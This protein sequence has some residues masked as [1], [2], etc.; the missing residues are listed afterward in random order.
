MTSYFG[1]MALRVYF[2]INILIGVSLVL[3]IFCILQPGLSRKLSSIQLFNMSAI[4]LF[5]SL[6]VPIIFSFVPNN[7]LPVIR[8]SPTNSTEISL[9]SIGLKHKNSRF[10]SV[11]NKEI[12]VENNKHSWLNQEFIRSLESNKAGWFILILLLLSIL[13]LF[14]YKI[15]QLMALKR[16]ILRG[17]QIRSLGRTRIFVSD[18]ISIPFSTL[19][20]K[21]AYVVLPTHLFN[22]GE[23]FKIACKHE[24]QHHRQHDTLFVLLLEAL[25][26]VFYVNPLV[27][28]WKRRIAELQ[29]LSCDEVLIGRKKISSHGYASC[30]VRVAEAAF[31]C[32]HM[33]VGTACMGAGSKNPVYFKSFLRRRIEMLKGYEGARRQSRVSLVLGSISVFLVVT[34]AYGAQQTLRAQGSFVNAGVA[35]FD[36]MVQGI[37]EHYLKQEID[38]VGADA[39]Y[40]IVSDPQTGRVLAVANI[41]K[42]TDFTHKEK[43]W[44]LSLLA[45]PASLMKGIVAAAAVDE[46]LTKLN[47]IHHCENG[48]YFYNGRTY[49]DWKPFSQ[50]TTEDT[51]AQ[52]SNI[53]GIKLAEKLGAQELSKVIVNFGFGQGGSASDFPEAR[54]GI[55]PDVN[56]TRP[57]AFIAD[58]ATG[59]SSLAVSPLEILQA[60]GAIANGG[61]LMRPLYALDTR[62]GEVVRRVLSVDSAIKAKEMLLKVVTTGTG[63]NT[64]VSK[65]YSTAGKTAT[66]SSPKSQNPDN[67]GGSVN[68]ASFVGF[69]P[70]ENPKVEILVAIIMPLWKPAHGSS[71]AA[72]VF[73]NIADDVLKRM[74]VAPDKN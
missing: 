70:V 53:C 58:V 12:Q 3:F 23:H 74:G 29:E 6:I 46:G 18:E 59:F 50:L 31:E 45:E 71:Q 7:N 17:I 69:A 2:Q 20:G 40:A 35:E 30:L 47:D 22:N 16:L 60:Y 11:I 38:S 49:H 72:P 9:K 37:A 36:P 66:A 1:W 10:T 44:A 51:V 28:L 24:L 63:S 57:E 13:F 5:T 32:R 19:L 14:L 21:Y 68:M 42:R 8:F 55:I 15:N 39:G 4:L 41:E 25:T 65:L 62:K 33:H 67:I 61:N 54:N 26:C 43:S 64:A 52:S 56:V 34:V 73:K 48:S 27:Y